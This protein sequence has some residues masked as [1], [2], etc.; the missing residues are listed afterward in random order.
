MA[1]KTGFENGRISNY[2]GLMT[3]TLTLVQVI[4]HTIVY[5][6]LTLAYIPNFI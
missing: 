2:E 6:S 5:H 3:S 4:W 1:E